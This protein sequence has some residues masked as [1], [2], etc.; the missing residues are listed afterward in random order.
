M[1]PR[2]HRIHLGRRDSLNTPP[3]NHFSTKQ[4]FSGPFFTPK[5]S[6][7]QNVA[8]KSPQRS[9]LGTFPNHSKK[10][11]Q[12]ILAQSWAE[13]TPQNS[14]RSHG[15]KNIFFTFFMQKSKVRCQKPNI[16]ELF[17]WFWTHLGCMVSETQ[18]LRMIL[19]ILDPLGMSGVRNPTFTNY[20]WDFG[21]TWDVWC[22]KPNIYELFLGFGTHTWNAWCWKPNIYEFFLN[23]WTHLGCLVSETQ[24]LRILFGILFQ[25]RFKCFP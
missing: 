12:P 10:N 15:V 2:D 5:R 20:F 16:Y 11:A 25:T 9:I 17:F 7:S 8:P 18:H 14:K 19:G 23:F 1:G 24:H 6:P 4:L 21:P 3:Q 13:S 22:Q